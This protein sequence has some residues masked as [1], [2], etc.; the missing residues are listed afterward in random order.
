MGSRFESALQFQPARGGMDCKKV[1]I[2]DDS[3]VV[4]MKI[5]MILG[6]RHELVFT[7]DAGQAVEEAIE[8]GCEHNRMR[9]SR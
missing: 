3:Q 6:A 9:R 5:R 1:L 4:P 7:S 2:V 8:E